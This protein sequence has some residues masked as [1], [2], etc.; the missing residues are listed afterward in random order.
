MSTVEAIKRLFD[1]IGKASVAV[2]ALVPVQRTGEV[3]GETFQRAANLANAHFSALKLLARAADPVEIDATLADLGRLID[4]PLTMAAVAVERARAR[5]LDIPSTREL[6]ALAFLTH[7]DHSGDEVQRTQRW[8]K[9]WKKIEAVAALIARTTLFDE[10]DLREFM[11]SVP[12]R[13]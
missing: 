3:A 11:P 12:P 9:R 13:R 2:E 8:S 6:V 7:V 4:T 10:P 5:R 1:E